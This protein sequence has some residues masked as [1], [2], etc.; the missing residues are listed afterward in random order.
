MIP[1]VRVMKVFRTDSDGK[2]VEKRVS[3]EQ[4]ERIKKVVE[5]VKEQEVWNRK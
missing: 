5:R 3:P 2:P 1:S 4:W